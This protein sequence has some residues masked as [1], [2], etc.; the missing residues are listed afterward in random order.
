MRYWSRLKP[1]WW[2]VIACT[3]MAL[4]I[5]LVFLALFFNMTPTYEGVL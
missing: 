1:Q 2:I 3:L 5:V 4:L